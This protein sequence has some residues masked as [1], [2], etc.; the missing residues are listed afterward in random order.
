MD[1]QYSAKK[2]LQ[3]TG[4]PKD[5]IESLFKI[6]RRQFSLNLKG[7][8]SAKDITDSVVGLVFQGNTNFI[9]KE[10]QAADDAACVV[11]NELNLHPEY[12]WYWLSK[13]LVEDL[14]LTD[15]PNE[16][17]KTIALPKCGVIILP[18][19]TFKTSTGYVQI[20]CYDLTAKS[21]VKIEEYKGIELKD[22]ERDFVLHWCA[23][24]DS[25]QSALNGRILSLTLSDETLKVDYGDYEATLNLTNDSEKDVELCESLLLNALVYA[26]AIEPEVFTAERTRKVGF[27]ATSTRSTPLFIG[28]NYQPAYNKE[29]GIGTHAS[30]S[31][32]WRRG[33]WHRYTV[34]KGRKERAWRFV[35]PLLI[36]VKA[37]KDTK[38]SEAPNTN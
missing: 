21:D 9:G 36:N 31:I 10:P 30:P 11:I 4:V 5:K 18:K 14:G 23:L 6:H 37:D 32:H 3:H 28:G 12:P 7:Y 34:G 17:P 8:P 24:E 19:K 16:I 27:G 38:Y 33:H 2:L 13:D 29:K 22:I 26:Q 35:Q 20:F 1:K 25:D 15:R